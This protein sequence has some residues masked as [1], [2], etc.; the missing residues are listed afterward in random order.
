MKKILGLIIIVLFIALGGF[1]V[2]NKFFSETEEE[3]QERLLFESLSKE[4]VELN[5]Y[6]VYGTHL[7]INGTLDKKLYVDNIVEAKLIFKNL[8]GKDQ[9]FDIEYEMD[10]NDKFT[11]KTSDNINDGIDL[12]SLKEGNYYVFIKLTQ[13]NLSEEKD[14]KDKVEYYSIINKTEYENIEYYTITKNDKNNKIDIIFDKY[15]NEELS[16]NYMNITVKN[17]KLPDN[18]YDVV[19]DPGHGGKDGGAV[20]TVN[21]VEY[22]EKD[23]TLEVGKKLKE[24]LETLGLKVKLTRDGTNEEDLGIY[25]MYGEDGRA[26]IPNKVK[27]KYVISLHLNSASYKMKNGGVEIYAP[28]NSKLEFAALLASNLVEYANTTY[29]PNVTYKVTDGVYV[30]NFSYSEIASSKKS[31]EENGLEPYNITTDTP[32]LFMIRE[33]GGIATN[34]YVDGRNTK[35]GANPYYNSNIGVES[36]LVELGFMNSD[37]DLLNVVNN[38]DKYIEGIKQSFK[39]FLNL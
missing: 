26:V 6:I 11:F 28:S 1:F 14:A 7:N 16:K 13:K 9:E 39:T 31:A 36:Y 33:P 10:D 21:G 38:Q 23:I 4:E 15:K 35:Y 29:S 18:V 25:D 27:A 20:S 37:N 19:I 17:T 32:Y 5:K 22:V 2:Y 24:E 3:K 30:R 12:E 34:A 8:D